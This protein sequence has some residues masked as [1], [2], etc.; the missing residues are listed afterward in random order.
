[1]VVIAA[2]SLF[3]GVSSVIGSAQVISDG[4]GLTALGT[5]TGAPY[6]GTTGAPPP[7]ERRVDPTVV[8]FGAVRAGLSL[9]LVMGAIGMLWVR[10][11]ARRFSLAFAVG[12]IVLGIVEPLVLHYAFGWPVVVSAIYPFLLLFAFNSPGW[13]ASFAR[14]R[15]AASADEAGPA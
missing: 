3:V 7:A 10:P 11:S 9:M 6:V 4:L 2:L 5:V 1:M 12:W 8:A 14:A 13:R 15:P